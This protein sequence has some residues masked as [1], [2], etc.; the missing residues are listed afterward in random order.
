MQ[1]L[2]TRG[3]CRLPCSPCFLCSF[4]PQVLGWQGA[5]NRTLCPSAPTDGIAMSSTTVCTGLMLPRRWQFQLAIFTLFEHP[6]LCQNRMLAWGRDELPLCIIPHILFFM[7]FVFFFPL[8]VFHDVFSPIEHYT[9]IF[10][11]NCN[12]PHQVQ[13]TCISTVTAIF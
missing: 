5:S 11:K 8:I 2:L 13:I 6:P 10:V 3:L 12:T 1:L 4:H 9:V 7:V